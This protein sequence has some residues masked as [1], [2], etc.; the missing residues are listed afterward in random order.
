MITVTSKKE[1]YAMDIT[2]G[3]A[4][5]VAD[6]PKDHGG[7]GDYLA[8]F[9][10]LASSFAACL[11]ATARMLLGKRGVAYD[12]VQA[13]VEVDHTS[14]PGKTIFNY[15]L[16]IKGNMPEAD[17]KKYEQMTF[18]GCPIHKALSQEIVFTGK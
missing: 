16:E 1:K 7:S 18:N 8:P 5:M 2:N 9:E 11:T 15:H 12:S 14:Q 13:K 6:V 17:K 10:L 3:K 4:A